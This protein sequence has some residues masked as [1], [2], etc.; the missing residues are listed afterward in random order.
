MPKI[1]EDAEKRILEV[2]KEELYQDSPSSFSM[3]VIAKRAGIAVGT[4]YHYYPDKMDLI[5][6]ILLSDWDKQYQEV[7]DKLLHA[8]SLEEVIQ[9][10][11]SLIRS[12]YLD[13]NPIFQKYRDQTFGNYY[14]KLHPMFLGQIASLW[15]KGRDALHIVMI[16]E[17]DK[18]I[19]EMILAAS[20]NKGIRLPRFVNMISR[21]IKEENKNE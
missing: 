21:F 5:A 7:E 9:E 6:A 3:R 14:F 10:I 13:H 12:F 4:I 11:V 18:I 2:A 8:S 20:R 1:I 15:E 17:S 19:P 16:E